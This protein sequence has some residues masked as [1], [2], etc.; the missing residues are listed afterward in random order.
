[1]NRDETSSRFVGR[2]VS[3]DPERELHR[4]GACVQLRSG[5]P[6]EVRFSESRFVSG[7]QKADIRE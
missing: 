7:I 6:T 1:M 5:F 3:G 2:V 4:P